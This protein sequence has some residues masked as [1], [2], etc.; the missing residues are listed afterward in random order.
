MNRICHV[1][2]LEVKRKCHVVTEHLKEMKAWEIEGE[3]KNL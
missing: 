2:A 1:F 3:N